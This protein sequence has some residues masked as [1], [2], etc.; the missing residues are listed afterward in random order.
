MKIW[1]FPIEL[2]DI[3]LVELPAGAKMLDIQVQHGSLCLWALCDENAP[4]KKRKI[5]I[6][7]T[8]HDVLENL[9]AYISTFQLSG[10][11]LVYHAFE[12]VKE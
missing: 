8:G 7:G 6:Y 10:G 3:Q 1:K 5:A 9:V 4:K 12:V 11:V 2:T